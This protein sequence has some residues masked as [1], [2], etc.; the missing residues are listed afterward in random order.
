MPLRVLRLGNT[1]NER[2]L[3]GRRENI[4]GL[5]CGIKYLDGT[6]RSKDCSVEAHAMTM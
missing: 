3:T 4:R 1:F 5:E 6:R 2:R